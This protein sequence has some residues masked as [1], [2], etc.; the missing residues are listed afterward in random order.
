VNTELHL[1]L[2]A[3]AQ[4]HLSK[5]F[6]LGHALAQRVRSHPRKAQIIIDS[7]QLDLAAAVKRHCDC[8]VG[9]DAP[10]DKPLPERWL[11]AARL[12]EMD[13]IYLDTAHASREVIARAHQLGL[14]VVVYEV[15]ALE[16]LEALWPE[17]PDGV[18]TDDASLVERFR[19]WR[20]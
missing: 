20:P 3:K 11:D 6:D 15:D 14:R 13:W 8:A 10:R 1:L 19:D 4:D 16:A 9:L 7:F 2:E 12:A 18:I 17:L 5:V